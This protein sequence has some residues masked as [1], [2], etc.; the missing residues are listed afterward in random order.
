MPESDRDHNDDSQ[1]GALWPVIWV[2][3]IVV[4]CIFFSLVGYG[5]LQGWG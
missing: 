5:L 3:A 4:A 1:F 2:V